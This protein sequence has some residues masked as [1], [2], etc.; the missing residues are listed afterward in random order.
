MFARDEFPVFPLCRQFLSKLRTSPVDIRSLESRLTN[1]VPHKIWPSDWKTR[2]IS[3]KIRGQEGLKSL[4]VIRRGKHAHD[5]RA[6]SASWNRHG[7]RLPG[8]ALLN[9]HGGC[10]HV[11]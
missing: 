8:A 11:K 3:G 7:E 9:G 4:S 6:S 2:A 10:R 5:V 1:T